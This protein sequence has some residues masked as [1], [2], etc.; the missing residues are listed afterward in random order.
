MRMDWRSQCERCIDRNFDLAVSRF[1]QAISFNSIAI[2]HHHPDFQ[3]VTAN[4]R[5]MAKLRLGLIS[6]Y[7]LNQTEGADLICS[8][9]V[10][11]CT[12]AKFKWQ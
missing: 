8:A 3:D 10:A 1:M 2:E 5:N 7:H 9:A 6:Y 12:P 4:I 11:G